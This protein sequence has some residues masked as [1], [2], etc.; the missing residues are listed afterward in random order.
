MPDI[1]RVLLLALFPAAGNFA[2]GMLAEA[3]RT[4]RRSLSIALH[5][6]AGIVFGV[7]AVELAPR[8]LE[9]LDAWLAVTGFIEGCAAF[10]G[11][12]PLIDRFK[13]SFATAAV[14]SG[15]GECYACG[16]LDNYYAVGVGLFGAG[17]ILHATTYESFKR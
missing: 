1:V 12:D 11:L 15:P 2:G 9:R 17:P 10:I 5:L 14:C 3:I 6:A 13:S 4:S 16:A 8:T 7:I